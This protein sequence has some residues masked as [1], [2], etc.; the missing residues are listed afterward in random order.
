MQNLLETKTNFQSIRKDRKTMIEEQRLHIGDMLTY[1][2]FKTL[3]NQ[4]SN[5][6]SEEEFARYFLDIDYISYLMKNLKTYLITIQ[7]LK[8]M[9]ENML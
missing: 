4:Y 9:K 5:Q 1:T 7:Y 6:I 3:Y 2:R 8:W